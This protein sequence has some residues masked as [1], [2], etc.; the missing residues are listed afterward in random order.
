MSL[1][2]RKR[3]RR[4]RSLESRFLCLIDIGGLTVVPHAPFS[5]SA[6]NF[7]DCLAHG[8]LLHPCRDNVGLL[9]GFPVLAVGASMPTEVPLE[10]CGSSQVQGMNEQWEVSMPA[11][12]N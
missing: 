5:C 7:V 4:D 3:C 12:T 10:R 6:D 8:S 9:I 2:E 1:S 11:V